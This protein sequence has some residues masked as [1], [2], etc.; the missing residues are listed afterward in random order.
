MYRSLLNDIQPLIFNGES[1]ELRISHAHG[2]HASIFLNEGLIQGIQAGQATGKEG[3]LTCAKWVS[4]E[5]RFIPGEPAHGGSIR[6]VD[7]SNF[8]TLLE[9]VQQRAEKINTLIPGN[10]AIFQIDSSKLNQEAKFSTDDFRIALLIDGQR[11]I[12]QIVVQAGAA[13]YDT[14]ASVYRLCAAGVAKLATARRPLEKSVQEA[15]L[16]SLSEKL[17]GMVGP[18]ANVLIENSFESL[19][20]KPGLLSRQDLPQLVATLSESLDEAQ[21]KQ[22]QVWLTRNLPPE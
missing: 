17:I 4:F 20:A 5:T 15:F 19:G 12:G 13:E 1:G 22:L 14:L 11:S 7:T 21:A 10:E 18:V 2:G 3:A 6:P 16:A 8:L 9:Q